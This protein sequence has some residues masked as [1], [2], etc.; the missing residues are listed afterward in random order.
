M[1]GKKFLE[2]WEFVMVIGWVK[3]VV[4]DMIFVGKMIFIFVLF[5]MFF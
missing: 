1:W 3:F 5:D 4:Y 2:L